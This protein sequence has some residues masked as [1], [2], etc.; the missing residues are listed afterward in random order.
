M[1]GILA[2]LALLLVIP[3]LAQESA[4]YKLNEHTFNAGGNPSDGVVL[5][6]ASYKITLDAVG[7][8]VSGPNLVSASYNMDGSFVSGYPPPGE[9]LGL[10]FTDSQTLVWSPE[11]SIG[12]YNL[13]RGLLSSL[14]GTVYGSCGEPDIIVNTTTDN[15]PVPDGDGHF[16]LITAENRLAEEGTRGMDS[17]GNERPTLNPCP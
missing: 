15:D 4:N 6:S 8:S 1:R 14:D 5:T 9:I 2:P 16:Y 12:V 10:F 13:Y 3:A 7:D 11:K 17:D